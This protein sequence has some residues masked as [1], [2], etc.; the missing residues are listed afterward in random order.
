MNFRT[1]YKEPKFSKPGILMNVFY[2]GY[3][4]DEEGWISSWNETYIFVKFKASVDIYG[5]DNSHAKAC[6]PNDLYTKDCYGQK[7]MLTLE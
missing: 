3:H 7:L 6:N 5:L 1:R 4:E 2:K